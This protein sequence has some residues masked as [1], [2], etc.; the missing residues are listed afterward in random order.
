MTQQLEW[1][2]AALGL[3]LPG[4]LER[5]QEPFGFTKALVIGKSSQVARTGV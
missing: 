5:S 3:L 4:A 2:L 1:L